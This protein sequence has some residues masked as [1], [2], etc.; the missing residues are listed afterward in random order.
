[1]TCP[2]CQT[3]LQSQD[4]NT[5]GGVMVCPTCARSLVQDK[6]QPRVARAA[7]LLAL[8][9]GQIAE[10]R[11]ARPAAWRADVRARHARIVARRG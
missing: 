7:D 9:P 6:G 11:Q 5:P 10:L 2:Q 3:A 4:F 8:T 1:M